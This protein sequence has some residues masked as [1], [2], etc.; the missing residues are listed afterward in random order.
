[1]FG[2]A[3]ALPVGFD[4]LLRALLERQRFGILESTLLKQ[5]VARFDRIDTGVEVLARVGGARPRL[6]QA[7]RGE[8]AEPH[9]P[10]PAIESEPEDPALRPARGDLQPEIPAVGVVARLAPRSDAPG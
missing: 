4:V 9:F 7:K 5:G 10:S 1:M 8:R 2:V 3:P 6:D